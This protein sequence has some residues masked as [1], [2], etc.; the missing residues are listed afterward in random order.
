MITEGWGYYGN[1]LFNLLNPTKTKNL[2]NIDSRYSVLNIL[3]E[4]RSP[5]LGF[6]VHGDAS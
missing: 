6:K 1:I 4:L 5:L 2:Q 3:I